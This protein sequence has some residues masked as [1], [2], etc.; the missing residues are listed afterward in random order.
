MMKGANHVL[1]LANFRKSL[2]VVFTLTPPVKLYR[3]NICLCLHVS[4]YTK[5]DLFLLFSRQEFQN[6]Y[7]QFFPNGNPSKFAGY[8]FNAFDTNKVR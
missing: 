5:H 7:Q 6:I 2:L 8:V 3:G 4:E 1:L